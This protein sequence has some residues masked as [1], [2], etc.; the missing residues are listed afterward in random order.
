V[1]GHEG[2]DHV[3][4]VVADWQDTCLG[5]GGCT[6]GA[7]LTAVSVI[8]PQ[9]HPALRRAWFRRVWAS[10]PVGVIPARIGG[11]MWCH[12][13]GFVEVKQLREE[14]VTVR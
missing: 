1:R 3:A 14:R 2:A 7:L 4:D 8:E 6:H 5:C 12:H 9:N 10:N 13:K 11:G